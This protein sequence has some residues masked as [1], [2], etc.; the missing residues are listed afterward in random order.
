MAKKYI[1]LGQMSI[2]SELLDF[3]NNELLPGTS[4]TKKRFWHGL[5]KYVHELAPINKK[6]LLTRS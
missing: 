4:I 6:L 3:V 5:D 1:S 2:A